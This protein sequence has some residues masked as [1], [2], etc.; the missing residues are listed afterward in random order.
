MIFRSWQIVKRNSF[1]FIV[2]NHETNLS[3]ILFIFLLNFHD[4]IQL[5]FPPHIHERLIC[6]H[7]TL[8][9]H[10]IVSG[11]RRSSER[12]SSS[13]ICWPSLKCLNYSKVAEWLIKSSPNPILIIAYISVAC[14]LSFIQNLIDI[15]N[16][17]RHYCLD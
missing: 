13:V 12:V 4:K 9:R 1:C 6:C 15:Y 3:S 10:I 14:L 17:K 11:G 16:L 8:F 2:N 5:K 7:F